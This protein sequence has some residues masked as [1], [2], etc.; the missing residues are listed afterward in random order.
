MSGWKIDNITAERRKKAS[1]KFPDAG[2]DVLDHIAN[3]EAALYCLA[4][5][6]SDL[7]IEPGP[8]R[9]AWMTS[10]M[11]PS[12]FD[13][14]KEGEFAVYDKDAKDFVSTDIPLE[15]LHEV[16]YEVAESI[17]VKDGSKLSDDFEVLAVHQN[18]I[19]AYVGCGGIWM[20]DIRRAAKL[21]WP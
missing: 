3:V 14:I 5:P 1:V 13:G 9:D 18:A 12:N 19:A 21:L 8:R 11:F 10:K 17:Y 20:K 4:Y 2:S 7:D 16:E 6:L 15:K